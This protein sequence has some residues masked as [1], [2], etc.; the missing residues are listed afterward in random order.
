MRLITITVTL[1]VSLI[2]PALALL[3][4]YRTRA[5]G[6]LLLCT[7]LVFTSVLLAST[8]LS[9]GYWFAV[10]MYWPLALVALFAWVLLARARR[11]MPPTW[12][13]KSPVREGA[14]T[15]VVVL[16]TGLVGIALPFVARSKSFPREPLDLEYPLR[17]GNFV[18]MAGGSNWST[19]SHAYTSPTAMRFAVDIASLNAA[20]MRASGISPADLTKYSVLG[21]EVI[22]PCAGEVASVR[23]DALD[24]PPLAP[25]PND[26]LGNHVVLLCGDYSVVLAQ[27]SRRSIRV[28]EGESIAVGQPLG[29][30]GNSGSVLEPHL[31]V[32][33]VAGRHRADHVLIESGEPVPITI[34][35][36][37]LV[38]NQRFRN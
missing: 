14:L 16:M 36:R 12:L 31:H 4:L 23:D 22:A 6:K 37:H 32:H 33:A 3:W 2:F 13:G 26:L 7:L 24:N 5:E 34:G 27:M 17:N 18:V 9:Y 1:L 29:T 35:G 19:N 11:G 21:S 38:K 25:N 20:G 15:A 10:G 28:T 8:I 30:V